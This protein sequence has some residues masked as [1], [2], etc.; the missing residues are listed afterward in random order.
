MRKQ[1]IIDKFEQT[2]DNSTERSKKSPGS[3][4]WA[5]FD[6]TEQSKEPLLVTKPFPSSKLLGLLNNYA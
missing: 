6:R 1:R 4:I 3:S 5:V 2:V